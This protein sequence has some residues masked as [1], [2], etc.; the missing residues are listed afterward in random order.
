MRNFLN[1]RKWHIW[2]ACFAILINALAPSISQ[3]FDL[4]NAKTGL[5]GFAEICTTQ[6]AKIVSDQVTSA[7]LQNQFPAK[8]PLQ[9][10]LHHMQHCQCCVTHA[11]NL[12]LPFPDSQQV[13]IIE[14]HD[15]YPALFYHSPTTLFSWA[16]AH[17]R[18]P[19]AS[20]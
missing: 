10:V 12:A 5:P 2:I 13:A 4:M 8:D 17:A 7:S 9:S 11:D 15:A 18:A 14:G 3:A 16:T 6:G 20:A 19:P 1:S